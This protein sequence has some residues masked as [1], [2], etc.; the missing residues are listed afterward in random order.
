MHRLIRVEAD[1]IVDMNQNEQSHPVQWKHR[2]LV[3]GGLAISSPNIRAVSDAWLAFIM[4]QTHPAIFFYTNWGLALLLWYAVSCTIA[5]CHSNANKVYLRSIYLLT[6]PELLH[7]SGPPGY[8]T[9][10]NNIDSSGGSSIFLLL[11]CMSLGTHVLR[12]MTLHT[13]KSLHRNVPHITDPLWGE[14][15]IHRWISVTKGIS[16]ELRYP[17]GKTTEWPVKWDAKMLTRR[18]NDIMILSHTHG[19]LPQASP[20]FVVSMK[21]T[22]LWFLCCWPWFLQSCVLSREAWSLPGTGI[23]PGPCLNINTVFPRRGDSHVREDGHETA[24]SLTW[25][26]LYW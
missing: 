22:S 15:S 26:S 20:T 8:T 18:D 11:L 13:V 2:Q 7:I 4:P 24:L 1:G 17:L 9:S 3:M 6:L 10:S 23:S 12:H 21:L 14:S 19:I 25:G 5:L 16:L